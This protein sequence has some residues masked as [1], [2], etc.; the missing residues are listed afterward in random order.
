[1]NGRQKTGLFVA[2]V[3]LA[4]ATLLH[5][6]WSGYVIE[7]GPSSIG[8]TYVESTVLPIS[9]WRSEAPLVQWF[10]NCLNYAAVVVTVVLL[11]ALWH[12][13]SRAD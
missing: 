1:M 6:P 2:A 9:Y 4:A 13:L 11:F 7:T 8:R 5:S 3:L 12:R 10:G